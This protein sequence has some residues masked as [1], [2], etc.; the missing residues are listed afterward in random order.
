MQAGSEDFD[1][2]NSRGTTQI[3][4]SYLSRA[5]SR[6]SSSDNPEFSSYASL[7]R[8]RKSPN[9]G[10]QLYEEGAKNQNEN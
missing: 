4:D 10:V 6:N 9:I 8:K 7:Q 1:E 5:K 2:T 3:E